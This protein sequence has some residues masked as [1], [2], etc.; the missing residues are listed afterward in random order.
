[1]VSRRPPPPPP[2]PSFFAPVL[3]CGEHVVWAPV[4]QSTLALSL[5]HTHIHTVHGVRPWHDC[6]CVLW[7]DCVC[8]QV[9]VARQETEAALLE[10]EKERR[11]QSVLEVEVGFFASFLMALCT[12]SDPAAPEVVVASGR[13]DSR[14]GKRQ[15]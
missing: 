15:E 2:S 8:V 6:V 10:L 14:E 12:C 11:K 9:D 5:S 7:Y 4:S 13:G 1:M 3:A